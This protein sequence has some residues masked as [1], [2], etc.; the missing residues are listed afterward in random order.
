MLAE[1]SD[2]SLLDGATASTANGNTHLVMAPQ[3]EETV[4]EIKNTPM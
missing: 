3:T 4:L 2:D 1:C